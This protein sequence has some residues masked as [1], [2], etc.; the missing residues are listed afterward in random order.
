MPPGKGNYFISLTI[1]IPALLIR[2]LKLLQRYAAHY[3]EFDS[4]NQHSMTKMHMHI[5]YNVFCMDPKPKYYKNWQQ[6]KFKHL[7]MS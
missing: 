1:K 6:I 3:K 7:L 2:P 5:V 4:V